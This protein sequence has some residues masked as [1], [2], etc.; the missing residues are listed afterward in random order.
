MISKSFGDM[1][2]FLSNFLKGKSIVMKLNYPVPCPIVCCNRIESDDQ[3][4]SIQEL[5]IDYRAEPHIEFGSYLGSHKENIIHCYML[6]L[7]SNGTILCYIPLLQLTIAGVVDHIKLK[8]G[9]IVSVR[10]IVILSILPPKT[11]DNFD[12]VV[13]GCLKQQDASF[14]SRMKGCSCQQMQH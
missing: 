4:H 13:V 6:G 7:S 1:N 9:A 8:K 12:N 10:V 2:L 5:T 3:F 14:I 11:L